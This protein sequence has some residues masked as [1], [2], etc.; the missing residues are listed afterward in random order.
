M[1]VKI[2]DTNHNIVNNI[3][4]DVEE[5]DGK[6]LDLSM[7]QSYLHTVAITHICLTETNTTN[8][9]ELSVLL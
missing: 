8:Y 5:R 4:E 9:L 3:E 7:T 2:F 6:S 1:K